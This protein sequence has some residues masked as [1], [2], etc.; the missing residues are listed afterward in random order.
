VV[1]PP[2]GALGLLGGLGFGLMTAVALPARADDAARLFDEGLKDML[3]G[4]HATG[5]PR[6]AKSYDIEPLLGTL[7]TLAECYAKAGKPASAIARYTEYLERYAKLPPAQKRAQRERAQVSLKERATLLGDVPRLTLSLPASAPP[8]T[9]VTKD[10]VMFDATS[11]DTTM[12]VD[13]GEYVFTT[14]VPGGPVN[15]ERTTIRLGEQQKIELVVIAGSTT[16]GASPVLGTSGPEPQS[17]GESPVSE[18]EEPP[19]EDQGSGETEGERQGSQRIWVYAAGGAGLVGIAV[20]S[21]TGALVLSE[22]KAILKEC[23]DDHRCSDKG[24]A[25]VDRAQT[26]G[27]VSTI[28]FAVGATGIAAATIL[29]LTERTSGDRRPAQS[30]WSPIVTGEKRGAMVGLSGHF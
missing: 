8:G 25:A 30:R 10:G 17:H 28:G 24:L 18:P 16:T 7:F 13:P 26:L 20:G 14:Q 6:I 22:R 19:F 5:C 2:R 11:L 12:L 15:E 3:A 9:V 23:D 1:T 27:V 29:L 21:V 4:R